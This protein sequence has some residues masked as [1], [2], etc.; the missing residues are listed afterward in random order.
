V[1]K[2]EADE[3]WMRSLPVAEDLA[4]LVGRVESRRCY[5]DELAAEWAQL[6]C[7]RSTILGYSLCQ[8]GSNR[9]I[10]T[11]HDGDRVCAKCGRST[12]S[13]AFRRFYELLELEV[14]MRT[15]GVREVLV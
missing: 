1:A 14:L 13:V 8:C 2:R 7:E 3:R 5:A 10:T 9:L 4:A 15:N 12:G 6:V 11:D